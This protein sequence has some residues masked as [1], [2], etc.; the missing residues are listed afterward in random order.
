MKRIRRSLGFILALAM[1][2]SMFASIPLTVS[3][4]G[5]GDG[6]WIDAY[7]VSA[8]DTSATWSVRFSARAGSVTGLTQIADTVKLIATEQGILNN[9]LVVGDLPAYAARLLKLTKNIPNVP[10]GSNVNIHPAPIVSENPLIEGLF[11]ANNNSS[12]RTYWTPFCNMFNNMIAQATTDLA[13]PLLIVT[14]ISSLNPS[15]SIT[16]EQYCDFVD[17]VDDIIT[18]FIDSLELKP[19]SAISNPITLTL[20]NTAFQQIGVTY[21]GSAYKRMQ[22]VTAANTLTLN[23]YWYFVLCTDGIGLDQTVLDDYTRILID[24]MDTIDVETEDLFNALNVD[25]VLAAIGDKIDTPLSSSVQTILNAKLAELTADFSTNVFSKSVRFDENYRRLGETEKL[26]TK[27]AAL[28]AEIDAAIANAELLDDMQALQLDIDGTLLTELNGYKDRFDAL[29]PAAFKYYG[30]S[31]YLTSYYNELLEVINTLTLFKGLSNLDPEDPDDVSAYNNAVSA[32]QK[33][34]D[35]NFIDKIASCLTQFE[36]WIFIE[37]PGSVSGIPETQPILVTQFLDGVTVGIELTETLNDLLDVTQELGEIYFDLTS[38]SALL[39]VQRALIEKSDFVQFGNANSSIKITFETGTIS[40]DSTTVQ[41]IATNAGGTN[42]AILIS[43]IDHNDLPTAHKDLVGNDDLVFEITITS[44]ISAITSFDGGAITITV[45]Y[46]GTVPNAVWY[47]N[48]NNEL[49][50]IDSTYDD[51]A[52]TI[53][54]I[55]AHLSSYKVGSNPFPTWAASMLPE[56]K[57]ILKRA[58][59]YDASGTIYDALTLLKNLGIMDSQM[60]EDLLAAVEDIIDDSIPGAKIPVPTE[61]SLKLGL[62][63]LRDLVDKLEDYVTDPLFPIPGN[64]IKQTAA[65]AAVDAISFGD[66]IAFVMIMNGK[67]ETLINFASEILELLDL[68]EDAA[69]LVGADMNAADLSQLLSDI[70]AQYAVVDGYLQNIDND[71]IKDVLIDLIGVLTGD[72]SQ[73][74][75]N[76]AY[77][78]L[79]SILL[80]SETDLLAFAETFVDA[81]LGNTLVADALGIF[82]DPTVDVKDIIMTVLEAEF[83]YAVTATGLE[84]DRVKAVSTAVKD[85]LFEL[86]KLGYVEFNDYEFDLDST[87]DSFTLSVIGG[88]ADAIRAAN[89]FVAEVVKQLTALGVSVP[90]ILSNNL[91]LSKV[92]DFSFDL[93]GVDFTVV[94]DPTDPASVIVTFTDTLP[95]DRDPGEG[96][97]DRLVTMTVSLNK[98]IADALDLLGFSKPN[99]VFNPKGNTID[100]NL[101]LAADTYFQWATDLVNKYRP[102]MKKAQDYDADGTIYDALALLKSLGIMDSQMLEDLL[103]AVELIIDGYIPGAKIPVPT[104]ASLKLGL[105]KLETL[106]ALLDDFI[107]N[108]DAASYALAKAAVDAISFGDEIA[109]VMIMNGKVETL[110][111]FAGEILEL[112]DLLEDAADLVG[113]DMNA[114]DLSQLLS[115]IAAQYAV[116]DGYLQNIDNDDIKDVLIDLIGVLTGDN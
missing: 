50:L 57:E 99:N 36:S 87:D 95:L 12:F 103:G 52:K 46:S 18:W 96:T 100:I 17:A 22:Q 97:T 29:H 49:E 15:D 45:P 64:A 39:N 14:A 91:T 84:L 70:A 109:F 67:V 19:G 88:N 21:T 60:L 71:D 33:A 73:S 40:L 2:F 106:V 66:E 13:S 44:G 3:A 35:I 5:P 108:N 93:H 56:F 115:D 98:R 85:L 61:A 76:T 23:Q 81:V 75:G 4:A 68:L 26:L 27:A 11:L 111:D 28:S 114:A 54:F 110:I 47:I 7:N 112:L 94:D 80:A 86:A 65:E 105:V 51:T 104:E 48:N 20:F 72:N 55:T 102:I 42:V 90:P 69:N 9:T 30:S 77:G 113:A 62:D 92:F 63:R 59:A 53:T 1:V 116:V 16:I 78:M 10:D 82:F 32:H 24:A 25:S 107:K 43:E 38:H 8:E 89:A 34:N 74:T 6:N 58:E 31:N 83:K 79:M 101:E 37:V 41:S